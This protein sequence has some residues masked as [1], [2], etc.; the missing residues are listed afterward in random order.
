M[1]VHMKIGQK[2][3]DSLTEMDF[4]TW[5]ARTRELLA[6]YDP[7]ADTVGTYGLGGRAMPSDL[8][9]LQ[10]VRID[11]PDSNRVC[12]VWVGG[13]DHTELEVQRT[14]DEIFTFIAHYNDETS[15]VIWPKK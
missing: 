8:R 6:S 14:N 5:T 7:K 2:Y 10:I 15:R 4:H 9:Q 13:M 1:D 3:M 12:Y 11:I